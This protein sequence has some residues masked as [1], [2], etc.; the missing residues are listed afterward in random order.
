MQR[1]LHITGVGEW[2]ADL[3]GKAA[4]LRGVVLAILVCGNALFASGQIYFDNL[5]QYDDRVEGIS[6]DG[7]VKLSDGYVSWVYTSPVAE[8][9]GNIGLLLTDFTGNMVGSYELPLVDTIRER[10]RNIIALDDTTL[11]A[12]SFEQILTATTPGDM[13]LRKLNRY[14]VVDWKQT[15]GSPGQL[16][17]AQRLSLTNDGGFIMAGQITIEGQNGQEADGWLVKADANG[18]QQW[19]QTYGGSDYDAISDVKETP[20]GGFLLLGWTRSF[21]AGQ[22]EWYLVK[23]D[24]QGNEEWSET[25]GDSNN[26]SGA[27]IVESPNGS[28]VLVGGGGQGNA[29]II[30]IDASGNVI[31]QETYA[32][33]EGSGSNYLFDCLVRPD[34]TIVA[35]G[36]SNNSGD[37]DAGWLIK[38][39][40][41]GNLLWQRKYNKNQYTDLFYSLLETDD[42]G[43]LLSGQAINEQTNSQDAWLLKVDSVGCTFPNCITGIDQAEKTIVVDVW[44]NP[45][46]DVLNIEKVSSSKQLDISVFDLSGRSVP[47]SKGVAGTAQLSRQGIHTFDVSHWKSGIYVLQGIDE[48]GRSFSLKVVKQ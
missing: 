34:S 1:V 31:W 5:Y 18:N 47:L 19:E 13:V 22:K 35:V 45:A 42:G 16:D 27:S 46:T 4:V 20:D 38:T 40:S 33:P 12:L 3:L 43:F 10:G 39:D 8:S 25:Y 44:P 26:Q 9:Y 36:G 23:T 6:T 37:G 48:E 7:T 21:G 17:V 41:D 24:A 2:Q 30:R 14:G 32:H 15:Y 11:I 28:Y 29:R